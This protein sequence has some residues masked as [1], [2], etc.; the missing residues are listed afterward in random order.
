MSEQSIPVFVGRFQTAEMSFD[1]K[2]FLGRTLEKHD[3]FGNHLILV[4]TKPK[5]PNKREPL[6]YL[7]RRDMLRTYGESLNSKMPLWRTFDDYA[8]KEIRDQPDPQLWSDALDL[9]L[10]DTLGDLLL[11]F[12]LYMEHA[13]ID[14]YCGEHETCL[15]EDV[16]GYGYHKEGL[17]YL[18]SVDFRRGVIHANTERFPLAFPTVDVLLVDGGRVWLGGKPTD[19]PHLWRLMGGFVDPTDG[20]FEDAAKRERIEEM[21]GVNVHE[22]VHYLAS[23]RLND[24]RYTE[25]DRIMG[26]LWHMDIQS[27][28][29]TA[30][31][32]LSRVKSFSPDEITPNMLVPEHHVWI[33][34]IHKDFQ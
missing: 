11:K 19:P 33:D 4:L 22:S 31:D 17:V 29:P 32:D 18:D 30:G 12:T 6:S 2:R 34:T 15:V 8:V 1:L 26:T 10:S 24:W 27:G 28:T 25:E 5:H 13:D 3:A 16:L 21:T 14:R 20:S 9:L 23:K 7:M